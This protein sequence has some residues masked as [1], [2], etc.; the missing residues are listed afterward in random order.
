MTASPR[1]GR[2]GAV[3]AMGL[4]L[5]AMSALVGC[6]GS[7]GEDAE[8]APSS[9]AA[10]SSTASASPPPPEGVAEVQ[11]VADS[12]IAP[13]VVDLLDERPE[14]EVSHAELHDGATMAELDGFVATA[15]DAEPD[16]LL[17]AGGT[18]DLPD[19]PFE[20][21]AGLE[22]RLR[23]ATER[24]CVVVAVPIFRYEP[25]TPEEI[26]EAT[27]GTRVLE[28][29]VTATGAV[30]VSYLDVSLAMLDAGRDFFADGELGD[31]HPG[32]EA[33]PDLAEAL[34]AGIATCADAEGA[35][36]T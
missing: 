9:T 5:G 34:A 20:M 31:L 8:A 32:I 25:G 28:D 15:L 33:H 12:E 26:A 3:A 2:S 17:Y 22:E 18:N 4:A 19:G 16:V 23:A 21:L 7:D 6:A 14:I 36:G 30:A 27:Q 24:A 11:V 35:A 10:T 1:W 29:A 13:Q